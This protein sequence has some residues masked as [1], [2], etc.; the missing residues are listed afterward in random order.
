VTTGRALE[1]ADLRVELEG[2]RVD[3][4]DGVSLSAAAGEVIGLVGESG[5]GKTTVGLAVLGHCRRGARFA[6]GTVR[7]AGE[8]ILTK[9]PEELRSMRGR[10]VSY[11]PQ[12]PSAAL[13]PAVRVETQLMET[14]EAHAFGSSE[15]DRRR[16]LRE[17]LAA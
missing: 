11:V 12:D 10:V 2:S 8:D 7:I 16:R 13:N 3:I 5:S 17:M 15:E 9:A 1:V 14:L 6:S 4:V